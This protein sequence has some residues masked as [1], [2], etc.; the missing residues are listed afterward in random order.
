[1]EGGAGSIA[2]YIRRFIRSSPSGR[3]P[4]RAALG[5]SHPINRPYAIGEAR[6]A[7]LYSLPESKPRRP[8]SLPLTIPRWSSPS[9]VRCAAQSAPLTAPGHR[10][11]IHL[12]M[13]ERGA[14][15]KPSF[16]SRWLLDS[17]SGTPRDELAIPIT[18]GQNEGLTLPR[19]HGP[20]S[21]SRTKTYEERH[22][23][24]TGT[25]NQD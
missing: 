24:R 11:E 3:T 8:L 4:S 18:L 14:A 6:P 2:S 17:A 5:C 23:R 13:R 19:P 1:V 10:D 15:V 25:D 22:Q 21:P 12:G 7:W 9:R 16:G 20:T